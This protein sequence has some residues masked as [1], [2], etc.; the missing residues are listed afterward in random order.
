MQP[1]QSLRLSQLT[2]AITE[3]LNKTFNH[4]TFW[5][6]ADVTNHT[7]R[8]DKNYHNFDLVEKDP[9]SNALIAKIQA[10][11]WGKGAISITNFQAL[12]GQRFTN[13]INVLVNVSV[14]FHPVFGLQLNVNE[15]DTN[16]TLGLLEQQ[17]LTTL[18]RLVRENPE[19]IRKIGDNFLTRNKELALNRVIQT[20]AV[21]SSKTSAG[22]QDF[23]HTLENNPFHYAFTVDDYFTVV[24][25]E[26]NAQQF[27]SRL[28]DVFNS[29]KNYDAVVIIRGGGAQTD[30]LI[31]D[32][33]M[34]GKAIAKF[35]IPI[36]TGI[37]H[38]KNE[39]IADL[40]AHTQTKT[41]TKAAEFIV[42]HNHSFEDTINQF[43]QGIIIK[44][45]Q[46][47]SA[48]FKAL[49]LVNNTIVNKSHAILAD[50]KDRLYAT[51]TSILTKP[52]VIVYNRLND[53][54]QIKSNLNTFGSMYLKNQKGYLAHFSS[55]IKIASPENTLK[56]G[57]AI[58]KSNNKV[59]GNPED[60]SIG[61][62]V[63][64]ILSNK[65]ITATVTS[66]KDY[67]GNDFKL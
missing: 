10:K 21:V 55:M 37:G 67:D 14:N 53:I 11:A 63:E 41:P 26:N 64:I 30:F 34:I 13:N 50:Y 27:L 23:R 19:F 47:F 18:A 2:A 58:I 28:I 8:P 7:F 40:M 65:E 54:S 22:W 4:L 39:T 15:I 66:K 9:S 45:Q 51:G 43:R 1:I 5:I 12:T 29:A 61:N 62:E 52:K 24:Q 32:D 48:D 31:F 20:I 3:T 60:L 17:R 57:F 38:Q 16:F 35:P 59:T 56:R 44:A 36:I 42:N 33:Y 46:K 6:V 49:G 25:G